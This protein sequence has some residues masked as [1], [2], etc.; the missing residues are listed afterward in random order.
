MR[1]WEDD[2]E[3]E[4]LPLSL[5]LH[6]VPAAVVIDEEFEGDLLILHWTLQI[7]PTATDTTRTIEA[8]ETTTNSTA[9]IGIERIPEKRDPE[10]PSDPM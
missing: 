9:L 7:I 4:P 8:S 6:G 10:L 5:P 3:M 2:E 1:R